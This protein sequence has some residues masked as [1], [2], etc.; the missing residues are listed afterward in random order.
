MVLSPIE[1]LAW[2][3]NFYRRAGSPFLIP[4][5]KVI[6]G[7]KSALCALCM[8]KI[9]L[10]KATEPMSFDRFGGLWCKMLVLAD[11]QAACAISRH[12]CFSAATSTVQLLSSASVGYHVQVELPRLS[13]DDV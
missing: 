11:H 5:L 4:L 1:V 7:Q 2:Q 8:S 13:R 6:S 12:P 9:I 3:L 10:V